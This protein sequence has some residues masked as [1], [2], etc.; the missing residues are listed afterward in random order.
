M[1]S[2][3]F[4]TLT[5]RVFVSPVWRSHLS[6]FSVIWS[7]QT[8][9]LLSFGLSQL[10]F[11]ECRMS[12]V[13]CLFSTTSLF[14]GISFQKSIRRRDRIWNWPTNF[15][16]KKFGGKGEGAEDSI[17]LQSNWYLSWRLTSPRLKWVLKALIKE[18]G[19]VTGERKNTIFL[20][21]LPVIFINPN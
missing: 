6:A 7:C 19:K 12:W 16:S 5:V 8:V 18:R 14:E 10:K 17:S 4:F 1:P 9:H 13:L 21:Q 11:S 20:L 15:L 3:Q 2:V